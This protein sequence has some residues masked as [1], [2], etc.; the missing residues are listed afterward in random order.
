[1]TGPMERMQG[2]LNLRTL[3]I[4]VTIAESRGLSGAAKRLGVSQ[5]AIS[6]A[7]ATL[8]S[9]LGTRLLDRSVRPPRLTLAGS[10]LYTHAVDLLH[11]ARELEH[12]VDLA[13][14]KPLPLLRIGMVDSFAATAGPHLIHELSSIA[15][16]WSVRSGGGDTAI[17]ALQERRVD[18][19]VTS[20]PAHERVDQGD[21]VA[22][23]VLEEDFLIVAPRDLPAA[24][25]GLRA[26]SGALPFIRYS[27]RSFIGL[28]VDSYLE[29]EG[30]V[31][32]RRYELDTSDAV[33]AMVYA[34]LGWTLTTPLCVLKSPQ[35]IDSVRFIPLDP[36]L[37]RSLWLV[38][39][40]SE[41]NE[42][43]ERIAAAA[44]HVLERHWMARIEALMPRSRG[45]L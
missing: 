16:R 39:R 9:G 28:Q 25:G 17:Q 1:M 19:L 31:L 32:E 43:A 45:D 11:R 4:F 26:L 30:I 12:L 41:G 27:A 36:P 34:Q 5:S 8:E 44:R 18:F 3:E 37:R 6:Q 22:L 20:D 7:I 33:L 14:D 38:A 21:L 15:A 35:A 42:L 10:S 40:Q 24:D 13:A 23:P 2:W 29:S